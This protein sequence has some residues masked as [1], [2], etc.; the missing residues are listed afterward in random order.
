VSITTLGF[1]AAIVA[2]LALGAGAAVAERN[3]PRETDLQNAIGTYAGPFGSNTITLRLN[4]AA[5]HRVRGYSEVGNNRRPFVG[6]ISVR[7]GVS[8]FEVREPGD[9][10][11]DGVFRFQFL[12]DR[13]ALAGTWTPNNKKVAAVSF[14]LT[15]RAGSAKSADTAA[16]RGKAYSP[17]EDS[18]EYGAIIAAA[19]A[20]YE[21]KFGRR[22]KTEVRALTVQDGWA[23][24]YIFFGGTHEG[25]FDLWLAVLRGSGANWKVV[26]AFRNSDGTKEDDP[27]DRLMRRKPAVPEAVID[28]LNVQ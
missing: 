16:P 21:R 17:A 9:Y 20:A 24:T 28:A 10:P 7:D 1:R 8:V 2:F 3:E 5:P 22:P 15:K 12:P 19:R 14:T 23:G 27:F 13:Q 25:D 11:D 18:K 4:D 26:E 6:F